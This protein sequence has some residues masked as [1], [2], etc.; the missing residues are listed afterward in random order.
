MQIIPKAR[1]RGGGGGDQIQ[2]D[3]TKCSLVIYYIQ[4]S[5]TCGKPGKVLES[6]NV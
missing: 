4:S 2:K 1:E 5:Y 3:K 6:L